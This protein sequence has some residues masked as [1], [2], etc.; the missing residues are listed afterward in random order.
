[1][2]VRADRGG[3]ALVGVMAPRKPEGARSGA[4]CGCISDRGVG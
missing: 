4:L 3:P 2:G 1:M